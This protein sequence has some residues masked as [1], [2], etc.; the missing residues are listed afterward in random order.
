MKENQR[1]TV[2][3]L[4]QATVARFIRL[5]LEGENYLHF[6]QMEVYGAYGD[7]YKVGRVSHVA[8]THGATVVSMG[9]VIDEA[10]VRCAVVLL[11]HALV[12]TASAV[13]AQRCC[14]RVQ[15]GCAC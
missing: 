10:C 9:P 13:G 8:A 4:P 11:A 1:R 7:Y 6:A 2:I 12:L 15:E 14:E 5:Q 3:S